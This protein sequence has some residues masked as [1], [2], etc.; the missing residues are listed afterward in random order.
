MALAANALTSIDAA[1]DY[2]IKN[3]S[4]TIDDTRIEWLINVC[5]STIENYCRR[6]FKTQTFEEE[7]DGNDHR[8]ISLENFP[9]TSVSSVTINGTDITPDQYVVKKKIGVLARLRNDIISGINYNRYN[10]IWPSGDCNIQV[11][12][13]AGLDEIPPDLEHACILFVMSFYKSDVANFSTTFTDGFVF[14]AD[15]IPVQVKLMLQPY[16]KVL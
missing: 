9:I 12:Y 13:T 6:I 5:S 15:S 4:V 11:T 16:M 14:K 2:I 10:P 3:T 8:Y 1:K 7:I